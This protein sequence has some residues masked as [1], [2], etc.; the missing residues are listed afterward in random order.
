[1]GGPKGMAVDDFIHRH[2]SDVVAVAGIFRS[3]IAE[4]Y[5]KFHACL[6]IDAFSR[7]RSEC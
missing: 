4:T 6:L 3:R 1:M 7:H 2:K 5:E